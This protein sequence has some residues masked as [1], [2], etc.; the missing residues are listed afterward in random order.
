LEFQWENLLNFQQKVV[1]YPPGTQY[2][3]NQY[4]A[5]YYAQQVSILLR[6][7]F[8]V[9]LT[10]ESQKGGYGRGTYSDLRVLGRDWGQVGLQLKKLFAGFKK[11]PPA[12]SGN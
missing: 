5:A 6:F 1:H 2:P 12:K 7:I 10:R 4:T 3:Y 11:P 9:A 8:Y